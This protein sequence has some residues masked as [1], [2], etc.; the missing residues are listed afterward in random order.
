MSEVRMIAQERAE[1]ALNKVLEIE[2]EIEKNRMKEFRN[3]SAGVPSI[4]LQNGFGQ[5]IAF[6]LSKDK[7]P[8][9]QIMVEIIKEWLLQRNF[10][11]NVEENKDFV[12]KISKLNQQKYLY[13]QDETLKLLEWVK[14]YAHAFLPDPN[15]KEGA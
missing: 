9:H 2:K 1:F 11:E 10:I 15:K 14:R 13:I 8:Q 6:F 7:S 12:L 3:F 5:T 4:I